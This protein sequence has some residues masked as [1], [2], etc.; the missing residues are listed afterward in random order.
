L[1]PAR[2]FSRAPFRGKRRATFWDT[3]FTNGTNT[4][5]VGLK[6]II[7]PV[8]AGVFF[9]PCTLIRIR[10]EAI[11]N[12]TVAATQVTF[13]MGIIIATIDQLAA[14]VAA[15]PDPLTDGPAPWLWWNAWVLDN[16]VA[17]S[18][19]I[20]DRRVIDAKAMRKLGPE[21][22]IVFVGATSAGIGA[23]VAGFGFATRALFKAG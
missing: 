14:G 3:A 16:I 20:G 5:A 4:L 6:V 8:A 11:A 1:L 9:P 13:A 19:A 17:T 23:A 10:G 21:N 2:R 7:P 22:V 15:F 12:G 18:V